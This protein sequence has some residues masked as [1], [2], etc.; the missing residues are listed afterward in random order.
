VTALG[1]ADT[2]FRM[3]NGRLGMALL[4]LIGCGDNA[5]PQSPRRCASR[6]VETERRGRCVAR[7]PRGEDGVVV[8]DLG[9]TTGTRVN[10]ELGP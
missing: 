3:A 5:S 10:G 2:L 7:R 6:T 8:I 9:S 1:A 4:V